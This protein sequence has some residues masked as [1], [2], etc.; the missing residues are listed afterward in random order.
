MSEGIEDLKNSL[1]YSGKRTVERLMDYGILGDKTIAGHCIHVN[2]EE[3]DILKATNT[4]VVNN[5]ESNM[6]NAVGVAPVIKMMDKGI[7]VGI[8]TDG[9]TSDMFES[10]KV[11]NIIHK[12]NL[13]NSNVGFM[14]TSKMI[15]N[16][17][18]E[19]A[20]K[21][22]KNPLG[23]LEEGA[24][25]DIIVVD[26][27]PITPIDKENYFGHILFGVCGR[28]VD[29]AIINGK[30]VMKD[31][32]IVNIDEELIYKKSRQVAERLWKRL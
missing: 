2:E 31:R 12:H 8:G 11:E 6:A 20:S 22:Y 1:M 3:I 18:K 23:V 30:V 27:N 32:V 17:N 16:N 13:C 4:N 9:Y 19:I 15:F 24:Y 10:M 14:E 7:R 26:Y 21:Y 28:S 29:T 25:A 5:P